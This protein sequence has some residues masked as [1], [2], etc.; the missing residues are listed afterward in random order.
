MRAVVGAA[1]VRDGAVL[2]ARRTSPAAAAG[3]WELPGGKVEP[4]ESPDEA[5]VREVAEELGCEVVVEEW[6]PGA[7]PVGESLRLIVAVCRLAAGE[8]VAHEHDLLRWLPEAELDD[9]DWL[10]P[11]LPFLPELRRVLR[12]DAGLG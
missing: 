4:D 6:L 5:L 9:V 12:E 7:S 2:A 3:R 10:E 1:I 11:D 8:P